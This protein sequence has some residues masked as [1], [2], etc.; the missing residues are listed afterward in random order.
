GIPF[1]QTSTQFCAFPQLAK[2][3]SSI[4]PARRS[5]L[6]ISPVGRELNNLACDSAAGPIKSFLELTLG[7]A[8]KH[9]PQ[10]IHFESS[11][12]TRPL[13]SG[14]P[15]PRPTPYVPSV[16]VQDFIWFNA[17]IQQSRAYHS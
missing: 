8:S 9:T 4:K 14:I 2:Q 11:Y 16:G 7:Q 10:L 3:L 5:L 12:A 13:F 15:S 6:F 17:S 1:G